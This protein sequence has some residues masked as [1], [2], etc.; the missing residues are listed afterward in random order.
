MGAIVTLGQPGHGF[1]EKRQQLPAFPPNEEGTHDGF[2]YT[3]WSDGNTNGT[4]TNLSGG[5]YKV[6]WSYGDF[7]AGKGWKPGVSGYG[8]FTIRAL[9]PVLDGMRLLGLL[10]RGKPLTTLHQEYLLLSYS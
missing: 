1:L 2:H 8:T 7:Y 9:N 6:D 5:S 10:E 4:Y 3:L